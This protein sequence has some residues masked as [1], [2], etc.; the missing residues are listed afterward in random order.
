MLKEGII[1]LQMQN[2]SLFELG[3]KI[4]EIK[5]L[6]IQKLRD[7]K[8]NND[9]ITNISQ[10]EMEHDT[11]LQLDIVKELI[12]KKLNIVFSRCNKGFLG[13]MN[14]FLAYQVY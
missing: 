8:M 5:G 14:A 7:Y 2:I 4:I 1:E 12:S 6:L 9:L 11:G 10:L 13:N 3:T